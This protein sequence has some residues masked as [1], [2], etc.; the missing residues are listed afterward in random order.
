MAQWDGPVPL[1][2]LPDPDQRRKLRLAF[3]IS[4]VKA[5]SDVGVSRE[6]YR[7]WEKGTQTPNP[8]NLRRYAAQ[9]ATWQDRLDH[10]RM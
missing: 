5:A 1:P 9:L 7:Q 10:V 2:V 3:G 4:I 8:D 6:T